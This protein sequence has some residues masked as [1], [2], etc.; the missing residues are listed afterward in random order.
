[1]G[2]SGYSPGDVYKRQVQT[3]RKPPQSTGNVIFRCFQKHPRYDGIQKS[4][5]TD[6]GEDQPGIRA[7][8]YT[9]LKLIYG[10][11][12]IKNTTGVKKM[13]A[14]HQSYIDFLKNKDAEGLKK[15][16]SENLGERIQGI[17][18]YKRQVLHS[19]P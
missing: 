1:M 3:S 11:D 16:L 6:S 4:L 13:I 7:V 10:R 2:K 15:A 14:E 17:D 5:H 8:S 9:H 19:A 12:V 18:V